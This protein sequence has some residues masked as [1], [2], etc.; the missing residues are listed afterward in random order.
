MFARILLI[1]LITPIVELALLIQVG[2]WIGFWPTMG[3]IVATAFL[4]SYMLRREGLAVWRRFNARLSAGDLPGTEVVDGVIVLMAG[5]LL[6]TPGVLSDV[7]GIL[8]LLPPTRATI[9]SLIMKKVRAKIAAGTAS[10]GFFSFGSSP[11]APEAETGGWS[12]EA[13]DT[14]SY[15]RRDGG[16]H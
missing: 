6:V 15:R 3:I 1:L 16:E 2:E 8:G 10:A 12:G 11:D 4:G 7:V 5:A 14:P 9:R 13:T